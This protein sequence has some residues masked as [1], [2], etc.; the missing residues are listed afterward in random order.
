MLRMCEYVRAG[1]AKHKHSPFVSLCATIPPTEKWWQWWHCPVKLFDRSI[2]VGRLSI[3]QSATQRREK[4]AQRNHCPSRALQHSLSL[5]NGRMLPLTMALFAVPSLQFMCRKRTCVRVST[6]VT[7]IFV[8]LLHSLLSING[9]FCWSSA[10][11]G[12]FLPL[13]TGQ[14]ATTL[15]T[16]DNR[17]LLGILH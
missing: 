6:C 17:V 7:A 5:R 12:W 14:L 10:L 8:L 1:R 11:V 16:V 9:I 13:P 4:D 3:T 2:L 15:A